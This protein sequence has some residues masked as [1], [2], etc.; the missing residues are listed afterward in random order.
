MPT[1]HLTSCVYKL[2]VVCVNGDMHLL[3]RGNE[4]GRWFC[5]LATLILGKTLK[6]VCFQLKADFLLFLPLFL[7]TDSASALCARI[8]FV[9][10]IRSQ[11][12]SGKCTE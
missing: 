3:G 1:N 11:T 8:P 4:Q 2:R 6:R 12:P 10:W 7:L 9:S 5:Y